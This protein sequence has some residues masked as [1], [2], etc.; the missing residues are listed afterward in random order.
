MVTYLISIHLPSAF[1]TDKFVELPF[2]FIVDLYNRNRRPA[3]NSLRGHPFTKRSSLAVGEVHRLITYP[4][5]TT[6]IQVHIF[7]ALS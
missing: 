5:I 4:V 3:E 6:V 2:M 7:G 1:M